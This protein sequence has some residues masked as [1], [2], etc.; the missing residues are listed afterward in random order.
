MRGFVKVYLDRDQYMAGKGAHGYSIYSLYLDTPNYKLYRQTMDGIK[1]RFKLRI[2]FYD[3]SPFSPAFL[4]VKRRVTETIHKLRAAVSKQAAARLLA[5]ARLSSADL[6]ST[7]D[8]QLRALSEFCDRR[9]G[10]RAVGT[11]YVGYQREAYVSTSADGVRVTFD[12]Q[13]AG[14]PHESDEVLAIPDRRAPIH[15]KRVVLELKYNGRGPAWMHDM[16][17]SFELQRT[18]FPKYLYSVQ[19]LQRAQKSGFL[20]RSVKC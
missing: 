20:A 9:D 11:V 1:N 5:G 12:R 19:A 7:G 15:E 6:L 17:Q 14:Y 8:A 13:I 3:A 18:V 2:R 4:E 16:I 10:L